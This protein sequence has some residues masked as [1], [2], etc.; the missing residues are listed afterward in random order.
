MWAYNFKL[1]PCRPNTVYEYDHVG[2]ETSCFAIRCYIRCTNNPETLSVSG[3]TE[4]IY[5]TTRTFSVSAIL[6]SNNYYIVLETTYSEVIRINKSWFP[7]NR[8]STLN[9]Y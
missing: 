3:L 6:V 9:L 2:A 8:L 5:T 4:T 7:W 1:L